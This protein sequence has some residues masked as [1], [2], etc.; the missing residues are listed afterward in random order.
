MPPRSLLP[1]RRSCNARTPA[2][3]GSNLAVLDI[4]LSLARSG[5]EAHFVFLAAIRTGH[6]TADVGR[7]VAER[8]VAV[9]IELV[10][11]IGAFESE[12]HTRVS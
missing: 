2:T 1:C 11:I 10:G 3:A 7:A 5:I 9:E 8:K 12:T 4:V 6:D